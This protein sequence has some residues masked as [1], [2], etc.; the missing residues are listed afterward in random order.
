MKV[1]YFANHSTITGANLSLIALMQNMQKRGA[2][3]K[4]VL[5]NKGPIEQVLLTNE[6]DY[7]IIKTY[8]RVLP[9]QDTKNALKL[10][11]SALKYCITKMNEKKALQ[12]MK[13]FR[14]D[15]VHIN[16]IS[17][18]LGFRSAKN[19]DIPVV[20]HIRELVEEDHGYVFINKREVRRELQ[21]SD[22][23][24]AISDSVYNKFSAFAGSKNMVRIYNGVDT[25]YYSDAGHRPFKNEEIVLTIAGRIKESKGFEEA[26]DAV[27][28]LINEYHLEKVI[29]RIAGD[30]QNQ[31][32]LD[33]LKNK[34]K[35]LNIENNVRF[36]GFQSDMAQV[37]RE[38]DKTLTLIYNC[39]VTFF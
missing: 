18:D 13:E 5:S 12:V 23:I 10:G 7:L 21:A 35:K 20:W 36:T 27:G 15:I 38:T 24:I 2:V 31:K 32:Y 6:I 4:L 26:I 37:W 3:C 19:L 14:P 9:K 1:L 25:Q 17:A 39:K 33:T 34:T 11:K 16:T 30:C 8:L 28:I 22:R 29:L